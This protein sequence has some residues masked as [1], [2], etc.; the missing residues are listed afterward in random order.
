MN[1]LYYI[2]W[3]YYHSMLCLLLT[4]W[5]YSGWSFRQLGA[6]TKDSTY[7]RSFSAHASTGEGDDVL[8]VHRDLC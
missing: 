8:A 3:Y 5:F 2:N 4:R 7:Q 1:C 6:L